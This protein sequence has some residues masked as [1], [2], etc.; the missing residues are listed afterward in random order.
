MYLENNRK[1]KQS[2]TGPQLM[3]TTIYPFITPSVTEDTGQRVR[4][5]APVI[6]N[7]WC[8]RD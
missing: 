8:L 1:L 3:V 7:S 6:S 4:Q 2:V 5:T